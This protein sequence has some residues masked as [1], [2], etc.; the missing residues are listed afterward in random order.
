MDVSKILAELKAERE[1]IEEAILSLERLARGRGRGP[2]RPPTWMADECPRR[3]AGAV[4]R[5]ARTKCSQPAQQRYRRD[6]GLAVIN[7]RLK[8][9]VIPADGRPFDLYLRTACS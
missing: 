6:C 4:R 9:P 1:Q 5:G 2:G 8:G 3:N 7:E